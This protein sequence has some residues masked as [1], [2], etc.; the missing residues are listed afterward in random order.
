[1]TGYSYYKLFLIAVLVTLLF[2]FQVRADEGPEY[3]AS[4]SG[5]ISA[6]CT[7]RANPDK[8]I[9][10]NVAFSV[11]SKVNGIAVYEFIYDFGDGERQVG[12]ASATHRYEKAGTYAVTSQPVMGSIKVDACKVTVTI[13]SV[14]TPTPSPK[15]TVVPTTTPV[16]SSSGMLRQPDTGPSFIYW[17]SLGGLFAVWIGALLWRRYQ[18][19]FSN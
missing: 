16:A 2:P 4:P 14:A 19:H 8:N 10:Q 6:S 13:K 18:Y 12:S 5:L 9:P 1:M 15:P 17:M 7:M 11:T 3:S